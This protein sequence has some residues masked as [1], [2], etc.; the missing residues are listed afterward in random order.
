MGTAT[1]SAEP[2]APP[3]S[4]SP[5]GPAT[6][7]ATTTLPSPSADTP[8]AP[9]PRSRDPSNRRRATVPQ[10]QQQ[11]A[12]AESC[13]DG[14]DFLQLPMPPITAEPGRRRTRD[15]NDAA[16][17]AHDLRRPRLT[18]ESAGGPRLASQDAH[19]EGDSSDYGSLPVAFDADPVPGLRAARADFLAKLQH[20]AVS[21][22]AAAAERLRGSKRNPQQIPR[23]LRVS[24]IHDWG[25]CTALGAQ[26]VEEGSLAGDHL[27]PFYD[28][29]DD[30]T[31]LVN[32]FITHFQHTL[33]LQDIKAA[34]TEG[35]LST[36]VRS[37]LL[38]A[39]RTA[40]DSLQ[41]FLGTGPAAAP[42]SDPPQCTTSLPPRRS[43]AAHAAPAS[44]GAR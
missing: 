27:Y 15:P 8:A 18:S 1:Q 11:P 17:P 37:V 39:A 32:M 13:L 9:L 29:S 36:P 12:K 25:L 23:R 7:A 5:A 35:Q 30:R 3:A 2:F 34:S 21:W 20:T 33:D 24:P 6:K 43:Q 26:V 16:A 4:S 44:G 31:A 28:S 10:Q 42:R 22:A 40:A 41:R 14:S 38:W 19:D